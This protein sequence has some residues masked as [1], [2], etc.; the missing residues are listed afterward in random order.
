MQSPVIQTSF[1][2]FAPAICYK[3][4]MQSL[5]NLESDTNR[6]LRF[7][8]WATITANVYMLVSV[9]QFIDVI[10]KNPDGLYFCSKYSRESQL[11]LSPFFPSHQN[12][13]PVC[14]VFWIHP[15][16]KR[17]PSG[18]VRSSQT[19]L[20]EKMTRKFVRKRSQGQNL[21]QVVKPENSRVSKVRFPPRMFPIAFPIAVL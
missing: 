21:I 20:P 5:T 11:E 19:C 18:L 3:S 1:T 2:K 9:I 15:Y 4:W 6:H 7:E 12:A 14:L 17:D 8:R 10:G 16:I 13:V